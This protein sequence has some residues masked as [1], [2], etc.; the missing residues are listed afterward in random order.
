MKWVLRFRGG[1]SFQLSHVEWDKDPLESVGVIPSL[2]D[3]SLAV[4]GQ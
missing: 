1:V 3:D 2:G 4:S